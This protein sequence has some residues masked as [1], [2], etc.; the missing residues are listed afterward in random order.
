MDKKFEFNISEE[1]KN[2][3]DQLTNKQILNSADGHAIDRNKDAY[4][5]RIN[6]EE[7]RK[8]RL[9][10]VDKAILDIMSCRQEAIDDFKEEFK[11][12]RLSQEKVEDEME[13]CFFRDISWQLVENITHGKSRLNRTEFSGKLIKE[14][15]HEWDFL[16]DGSPKLKSVENVK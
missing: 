2:E 16:S 1:R 7:L 15:F 5:G 11:N 9:E 12:K 3:L 14:R 13:R 10:Y 8:K 6:Q 4:E